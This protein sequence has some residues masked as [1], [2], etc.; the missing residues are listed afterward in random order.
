MKLLIQIPCYNEE[1]TLSDVIN[2]IREVQRCSDCVVVKNL[3]IQIVDDGSK[4]ATSAVAE[5]CGV[6]YILKND[7]NMG[8]AKTFAKGAK[9]AVAK[10][11]DILINLDGDNQYSASSIPRLVNRYIETNADIVVGNRPIINHPEFS[12]VKKLFQLLGS[13]VLRFISKTN[14]PDAASGFRLYTIKYL[15]KMKVY[16]NF[17]YCMETLIEAGSNGISVDSVDI[18]VNKK[19]R[20][21][22]LFSSNIDYVK[23]Q[24]TTML[25]A[26]TMHQPLR[27][28]FL[29]GMP[30]IVVAITLAFRF[31][32]LTYVLVSE[33][34][35]TYLPSLIF[36][37]LCLSIF[38]ISL[39]LGMLA[40]VLKL[41]RNYDAQ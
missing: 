14:V 18:E 24:A 31:I 8:L 6:D 5:K 40:E 32:L 3:K 30:F 33:P 11:F 27:F 34:E 38:V 35:R 1:A 25:I 41:Q 20:E 22:R 16:T 13:S 29:V 2:D 12:N 37:G 7:E 23:K 15:S 10:N 9:A 4:D 28:Y 36:S 17:S 39:M 26:F 19:T 21:S